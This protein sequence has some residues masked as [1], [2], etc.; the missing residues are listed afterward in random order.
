V[1]SVD[2][3]VDGNQYKVHF[4]SDSAKV[5]EKLV[6]D[7]R[8]AVENSDL[9]KLHLDGKKLYLIQKISAIL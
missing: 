6:G 8:E 4:D 9:V 3:L 5:V 7:V 1:T 2:C